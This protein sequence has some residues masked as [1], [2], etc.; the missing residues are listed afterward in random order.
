[1]LTVIFAKCRVL[2]CYAGCHCAQCRF[3]ECRSAAKSPF[4]DV[5]E[6]KITKNIFETNFTKK[7]YFLS[8]TLSLSFKLE[9]AFAS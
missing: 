1:M 2:Y 7:K 5:E 8:I 9:L 4:D 3:G 6:N